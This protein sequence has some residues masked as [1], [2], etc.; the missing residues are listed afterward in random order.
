MFYLHALYILILSWNATGIWHGD[1]MHKVKDNN[2]KCND[3]NNKILNTPESLK[4]LEAIDRYHLWPGLISEYDLKHGET[5]SLFPEVLEDIWNHQHPVD[6][7]NS[8]FLIA[9]GWA[10]GFGSEMH[11]LSVGFA[12]ALNLNRIFVVNPFSMAKNADFLD[13]TWQ[14]NNSFCIKQNKKNLECYYEPLTNCS[15]NDILN[16]KNNIN[17]LKSDKS[18]YISDT[19][20]SNKQLW[21][22]PELNS[23]RVILLE[24]R[25]DV[26][27]AYPIRFQSQLDCSRIKSEAYSYWWRAIAHAYLLRPNKATLDL[28]QE[29]R[30]AH[31][32]YH[33]FKK[34]NSSDINDARAMSVHDGHKKSVTNGYSSNDHC[35]STYVRRGDKHVE[36]NLIQTK[37]YLK[38]VDLFWDEVFSDN[39]IGFLGIAGKNVTK[40]RHHNSKSTHTIN[41]MLVIGSE[42]PSA[43]DDAVAWGNKTG[44]KVIFTDLFDRHSVSASLNYSIQSQQRL[45]QTQKHHELE[46]FSMLL[47]LD[48]LLRC[49]AFVC[50]MMSNFCRVIDLLRSTVAYKA[51]YHMADLNCGDETPCIDTKFGF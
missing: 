7:K 39:S 16:G 40:K 1:D 5:I 15:T 34:K 28:I 22:S 10:Q 18:T 45:H 8:K 50:T 14:T 46:Y 4:I 38:Q 25:G 27:S 2:H 29:Y 3:I 12:L 19:D 31:H 43:I 51:N 42:D 20:I 23:A 47:N 26:S 9:Q 17:F 11:I 41:K 24:N 36:M 13:N 48:Y 37:Y 49:Q 6:C 21:N 30:T 35:I 32:N 44:W 33:H